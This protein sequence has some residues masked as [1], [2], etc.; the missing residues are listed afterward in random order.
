[1]LIISVL[2]F[3]YG[4]R[5]KKGLPRMTRRLQFSY[6]HYDG[7]LTRIWQIPFVRLRGI[8]K[9]SCAPSDPYPWLLISP[10]DLVFGPVLAKQV[11]VHWT[12]FFV[13]KN[14]ILF[15]YLIFILKSYSKASVGHNLVQLNFSSFSTTTNQL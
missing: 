14:I 3:K 5:F 1:M 4:H 8:S 2:P 10:Y 11:S 12:L 9:A 6:V 13:T 7:T 15:K